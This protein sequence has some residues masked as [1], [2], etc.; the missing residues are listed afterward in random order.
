M[1]NVLQLLFLSKLC[2]S[3]FIEQ[4]H[5]YWLFL[6][7]ILDFENFEGKV[8]LHQAAIVHVMFSVK[9]ALYV[10]LINKEL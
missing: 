10:V 1:N 2:Y 8:T 9:L 7:N 4:L 3:M 6:Y 5:L